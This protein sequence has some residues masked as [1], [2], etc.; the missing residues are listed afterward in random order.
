[1]SVLLNARCYPMNSQDGTSSDKK[2][3]LFIEYEHFEWL[4][5]EVLRL[6]NLARSYSDRGD[7]LKKEVDRLK[8]E[9]N[10]LKNN[11][12]DSSRTD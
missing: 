3:G 8:T 9:L 7:A 1:M 11:H 6:G 2:D 4:N 10:T 5:H 12:N